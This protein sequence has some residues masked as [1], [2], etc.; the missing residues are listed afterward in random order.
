[1]TFTQDDVARVAKG[2]SRGQRIAI[3]H[4]E[5]ASEACMTWAVARA[6]CERGIT[7]RAARYLRLTPPLG[8]A[9][10][11]YLQEHPDV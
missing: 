11:T 7:P 4:R 3:L 9:V 6:L 5:D 8:L 2:L 1:M 10:K